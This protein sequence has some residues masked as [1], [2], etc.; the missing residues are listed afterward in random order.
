MDRYNPP[1]YCDGQFFLE[2]IVEHKAHTAVNTQFTA[3]NLPKCVGRGGVR[4]I[5]HYR[6][7]KST[8]CAIF[9]A[10]IH[11]L[12]RI[13]C[14]GVLRTG[15]FQSGVLYKCGCSRC[16]ATEDK[17]YHATKKSSSA[18]A[19]HRHRHQTNPEERNRRP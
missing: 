14:V 18:R 2:C 8:F 17:K 12:C 3:V 11:A 6:L 1:V 15:V 16:T 10:K 19:R 7:P 9:T 5:I 4:I 13:A